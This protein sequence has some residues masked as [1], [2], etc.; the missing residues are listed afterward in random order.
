MTTHVKVLGVLYI[1]L[2]GI[3]V[4]AALFLGLALGTASG[5]VGQPPRR[6]TPPW[7][8]RSSASPEAR[9]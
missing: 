4:A 3:F 6:K 7:R 1:V 2:S 9:W 5:I 8:C